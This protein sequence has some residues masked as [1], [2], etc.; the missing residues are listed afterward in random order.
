MSLTTLCFSLSITPSRAREVWMYEEAN[1]HDFSRELRNY[2]WRFLNE[3]HPDESAAQFTRTMLQMAHHFIP[4]RTIEVRNP[5]LN[6]IC[7]QAIKAKREAVGTQSQADATKRCSEVLLTEYTC[8]VGRVRTKLK[9]IRR[10]SK[11]W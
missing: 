3:L 11:K 4:T 7:F 10:G 6:D 9:K 2:D 8:H 1:W 5:W